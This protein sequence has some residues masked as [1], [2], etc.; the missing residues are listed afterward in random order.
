LHTCTKRIWKT[1]KL[2]PNFVDAQKSSIYCY[3]KIGEY[4][5]AIEAYIFM[6]QINEESMGHIMFQGNPATFSRI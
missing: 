3:H 5:K 4:N 2:N 6:P 1:L